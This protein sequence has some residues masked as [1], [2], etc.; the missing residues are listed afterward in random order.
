MK[1]IIRLNE[2]QLSSLI[3]RIINENNEEIPQEILDCPSEVLTLEDLANIPTCVEL[4]TTIMTTQKL[5]TD[6]QKGMRCGSELMSLNKTP[7]DNK[8]LELCFEK[9]KF[10]HKKLLIQLSKK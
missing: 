2:S 9:N 5:P 6:F 3:R 8:V 7:Q 10:T 1:K 4:T